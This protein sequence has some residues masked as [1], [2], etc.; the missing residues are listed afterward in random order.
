MKTGS[1]TNKVTRQAYSLFYLVESVT[2]CSFAVSFQRLA[3]TLKDCHFLLKR[4][5][6]R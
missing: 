1:G 2:V 3:P 5:L 4:A 6:G